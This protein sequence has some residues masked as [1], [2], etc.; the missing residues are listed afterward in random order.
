[1]LQTVYDRRSL[2][3]WH[4]DTEAY[5]AN[6]PTHRVYTASVLP[7][8]EKTARGVRPGRVRAVAAAVAAA[9]AS[10]IAAGAAA[11]STVSVVV[12]VVSVVDSVRM[13]WFI[14]REKKQQ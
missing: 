12:A 14:F 9:A 6:L 7:E 1:M 3:R 2:A 13:Y 8:M 11:A 5:A 10:N 4:E